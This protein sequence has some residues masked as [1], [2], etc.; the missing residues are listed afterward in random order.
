MAAL[1]D[2]LPLGAARHRQPLMAA[3][4]AFAAALA[5]LILPVRLPNEAARGDGRDALPP[6]LQ[7][8]PAE[9]LGA[10][11]AGRR[12]GV[13]LQE[14]IAQAEGQAEADAMAP[15]EIRSALAKIG[16]VG[17]MREEGKH[18]V[19]LVLPDGRIARLAGGDALPDGRVLAS[20][21]G[22]SLRLT[23]DDGQEEVLALFPRLEAE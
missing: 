22:H 9:D 8:A 12:W 16:F 14:I 5:A 1:L 11:L 7:Q 15:A 3:L 23:G 6:R 17:L 4:L 19:L 18:A 2:R 13:S 10:F 20:V 21:A